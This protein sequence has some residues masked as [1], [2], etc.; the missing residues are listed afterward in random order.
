MY[1]I[2]LGP[3][4]IDVQC[5]LTSSLGEFSCYWDWLRYPGLLPVLVSITFSPFPSISWCFSINFSPAVGFHSCF[6]FMIDV[7]APN[8]STVHLLMVSFQAW[9][10]LWYP[11]L[12]SQRRN[13]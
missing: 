11:V 7:S 1:C 10:W 13:M 6:F 8:R 2:S 9:D 12:W 3:L 4:P 5:P